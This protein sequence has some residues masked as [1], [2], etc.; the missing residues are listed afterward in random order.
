MD[1]WSSTYLYLSTCRAALRSDPRCPD[2]FTQLF[3]LLPFFRDTLSC[4]L[5][6]ELLQDAVSLTSPSCR[7]AVCRCCGESMRTKPMSSCCRTLGVLEENQELRVLV[8]CYRILCEYVWVLLASGR[9]VSQIQGHTEVLKMLQEV[10][11]LE[12][13]QTEVEEEVS[14][15][16]ALG[17]AE[18][19]LGCKTEPGSFCPSG[20][21]EN[22]SSS[23]ELEEHW[24]TEVDSSPFSIRDYS[25]VFQQ[26]ITD[27]FNVNIS[28]SGAA[29]HSTPLVF[30]LTMEPSTC[31]PQNPPLPCSHLQRSCGPQRRVQSK[32]KPSR[33]RSVG[34][35]LRTSLQHRILDRVQNNASLKNVEHLSSRNLPS[36]SRTVKPQKKGTDVRLQRNPRRWAP[37]KKGRMAKTE[38]KGCR[39]GR[40]VQNPSVL[41]CRGQRCPCYSSRKACVQCVCRGCQNLFTDN[42]KKN[43]EAFALPEKALEQRS[44]SLGISLSVQEH[45]YLDGLQKT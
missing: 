22:G 20:S 1:P 38:T 14:P 41:T 9:N 45:S 27:T 26:F 33:S 39:C 18:G 16:G 42:G 32:W 25:L 5:C 2:T 36:T 37:K 19:S 11:E 12:E 6:G 21:L 15:Q 17:G 4:L 28:D 44:L 30:P 40:S 43:L 8:E 13:E 31:S 34:V 23:E 29:C 7:H 24:K 3:T 10:L 35:S